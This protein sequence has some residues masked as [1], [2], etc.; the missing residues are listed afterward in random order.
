M[1]LMHPGGGSGDHMG[2]SIADSVHVGR[3]R[4]ARASVNVTRADVV[5]RA[6][7][8]LA[9]W[10]HRGRFVLVGAVNVVSVLAR[11]GG[12]VVEEL[13]DSVSAK[14]EASAKEGADP[15]NPVVA[16]EADDDGRAKGASRVGRSASVVCASQVGNEKR[17]ANT[18]GGKECGAVL[19]NGEEVDGKHQLGSQEH[20]EEDALHWLG[21]I[22]KSVSNL[23][24]TGEDAI[25]NTSGCNTCD[26]L[27]RDDHGSAEGLDS[28]DEN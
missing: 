10:F 28:T 4:F 1:N 2:I 15:V 18:D 22:S 19:L 12:A 23:E 13:H 6:V 7:L 5:G 3:G 27:C 21:T 8:V 20:L 14:G 17:S 25:D 9:A 26:E 11:V 24:G 16:R